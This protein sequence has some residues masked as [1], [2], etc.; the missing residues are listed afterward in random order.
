MSSQIIFG[1]YLSLALVWCY[2]AMDILLP[3]IPT[4]VWDVAHSF[5]VYWFCTQPMDALVLFVC[6]AI[7]GFIIMELALRRL[8]K[9]TKAFFH[10]AKAIAVDVCFLTKV[11]ALFVLQ[12]SKLY[13]V[14]AL[15]IFNQYSFAVVQFV[16]E[17]AT[18][19]R[20]RSAKGWFSAVLC[21]CRFAL[22]CL[23]AHWFM[24]MKAAEE[25]DFDVEN[26][27]LAFCI[28]TFPGLLCL[29]AHDVPSSV[30][31]WWNS[32]SDFCTPLSSRTYKFELQPQELNADEETDQGTDSDKATGT[33]QSEDAQ[34][35]DVFFDALTEINPSYTDAGTQTSTQPQLVISAVRTNVELF[36][37]IM[38]F[39]D[40]VDH[41]ALLELLRR[42]FDEK[43]ESDNS[44]QPETA[45]EPEKTEELDV[46]DQEKKP[47]R[48][49]HRW[50]N[51]FG[52]RKRMREAYTW[53]NPDP[54]QVAEPEIPPTD[55]STGED[56]KVSPPPAT[57]EP[58]EQRPDP[59]SL[60][61]E[62]Q[63]IMEAVA[64]AMVLQMS[65]RE[66]RHKVLQATLQAA[67]QTPLPAI[68]EKEVLAL[69]IPS[70]PAE[71]L[72]K[73]P[74]TEPFNGQGSHIQSPAAIKQPELLD[75]CVPSPPAEEPE[76]LPVTESLN[77]EGLDTQ[78]PPAAIKE[79]ELPLAGSP[80]DEEQLTMNNLSPVPA[81]TTIEEV[82]ASESSP[83]SVIFEPVL[84]ASNDAPFAPPNEEAQALPSGETAAQDVASSDA[85]I[86]EAVDFVL[87]EGFSIDD[88]EWVYPEEG[89]VSPSA[90]LPDDTVT[91]QP[92]DD[93]LD[94]G[95]IA[96]D[97]ASSSESPQQSTPVP[98]NNNVS[99]GA[100]IASIDAIPEPD[101]DENVDIGPDPWNT[102][103]RESRL[104]DKLYGHRL[105]NPSTS[106]NTETPPP[107]PEPTKA[108]ANP[109]EAKNTGTS[110]AANPFFTE[111]VE[112]PPSNPLSNKGRKRKS[113]KSYAAQDTEPPLKK[114]SPSPITETKVAKSSASR[115]KKPRSKKLFAAEPTETPLPPVLSPEITSSV[116]PYEVPLPPSPE[117]TSSVT[118]SSVALPPSPEITSSMDSFEVN[119]T[120]TS[121]ALE[122]L[123]A[124]T[125]NLS[126]SG[127]LQ[128]QRQKTKG[129]GKGRGSVSPLKPVAGKVIKRRA[130]VPFVI[131]PILLKPLITKSTGTSSPYSSGSQ[132][133]EDSAINNGSFLGAFGPAQS[134]ALVYTVP[135]TE[136]MEID[137]S[138]FKAPAT[139][140]HLSHS[141]RNGD[142]PMC[143][144][145][146]QPE[147]SGLRE[148]AVDAS[149]QGQ[150]DQFF[151]LVAIEE[152]DGDIE[153][154]PDNFDG[155]GEFEVPN[156]DL[157]DRIL[158]EDDE[159][160]G[161]E[162][163]PCEVTM[164]GANSQTHPGDVEMSPPAT[165]EPS[166]FADVDMS[167]PE[168]VEV[169]QHHG[170]E[171]SA[172]AAMEF[173]LSKLTLDTD[174]SRPAGFGVPQPET[175][176][177]EMSQPVEDRRT[178]DFVRTMPI[179]APVQ[180]DVAMEGS[181]TDGSMSVPTS[182]PMDDMTNMGA[183]LTN[184]G[185]SLANAAASPTGM[186]PP[187]AD[188]GNS[189][190][191]Q[192]KPLEASDEDDCFPSVINDAVNSEETGCVPS[193][194][195]QLPIQQQLPVQSR[196]A[197]Q[198][199]LQAD[200]QHQEE[201][202]QQQNLQQQEDDQQQLQHE[203][204]QP[205]VVGE[206]KC[207]QSQQEKDDA[208]LAIMTALVDEGLEEYWR[209][210]AE[211]E[212][213]AKEE[214]GKMKH[215]PLLDQWIT[216]AESSSAPL[217][218]RWTAGTSYG[219]DF[220]VGAKVDADDD[221]DEDSVE[222]S[223]EDSDDDDD[224]PI[225]PSTQPS[226]QPAAPSASTIPAT[227]S[228]PA[229]PPPFADPPMPA[230]S[231]PPRVEATS[232]PPVPVSSDQKE[233]SKITQ[234]G[235]IAQS[236]NP[237]AE[238]PKPVFQFGSSRPTYQEYG[239][240]HKEVL[241]TETEI[242]A[243]P[244]ARAVSRRTTG[245]I[246]QAPQPTSEPPTAT[247][248]SRSRRT[249]RPFL[250]T[251][252]IR[253]NEMGEP[254]TESE[255]RARRKLRPVGV[256]KRTSTASL[257][258]TQET[259]AAGRGSLPPGV[260]QK[261]DGK[262]EAGEPDESEWDSDMDSL[263]GIDR[264]EANEDESPVRAPEP[265]SAAQRPEEAHQRANSRGQRQPQRPLELVLPPGAVEA[266]RQ[267]ELQRR[268]QEASHQQDSAMDDMDMSTSTPVSSAPA[269]PSRRQSVMAGT[270][271]SRGSSSR[272]GSMHRGL[273][274]E[275]PRPTRTTQGSSVAGEEVAGRQTTPCRGS[276]QSN[277][278]DLETA[279]RL[280]AS[281]KAERQSVGLFGADDE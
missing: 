164:P 102:P 58:S 38:G 52:R 215:M 268:A 281:Q 27:G 103:V 241:N 36:P 93:D 177:V 192:A 138:T 64:M 222:D 210:E 163:E 197:G 1:Y 136:R 195:R 226:T 69:H 214:E 169:H 105:R 270:P 16:K 128:S 252:D 133:R 39:S 218:D 174:M 131:A 223:V 74:I 46:S 54:P 219:V 254:S 224:I 95:K 259:T 62:G 183:P 112:P 247:T 275:S 126:T 90:F 127:P 118:P 48:R 76:Q 280:M 75:P 269:I 43:A 237:A 196:M 97:I 109:F 120:A 140:S 157:L 173:G 100:P 117:V 156:S 21:L 189:S 84:E 248:A 199:Q 253:H 35:E 141:D 161:G 202:Q 176:D 243:R 87:E 7:T 23:W 143:D 211:K 14:M 79:S 277:L 168:D 42:R 122:S 171:M 165:Y 29:L 72:E 148:P 278:L 113:K 114:S 155:Q 124:N 17:H 185:D 225:R 115:V 158:R 227:P 125:T 45:K 65:E 266:S 26:F 99:S 206:L 67:I 121:S 129:K 153:M 231:T 83:V 135:V 108:A 4:P 71:E 96:S 240:H 47:T 55:P 34:D 200:Q 250:S 37:P 137:N 68:K 13:A 98:E 145:A 239:D 152:D 92:P 22:V 101:S 147:Q 246:V 134:A 188:M 116:N 242:A 244:K 162:L 104:F 89:Y 24:Q 178:D 51:P 186:T 85:P 106:Q 194:H 88:H 107:K 33:N 40:E 61:G 216:K 144:P 111:T 217:V 236:A 262:E 221:S 10:V 230:S 204:Q 3:L 78:S 70:P 276:Q 274:R 130:P 91:E 31:V 20:Q 263:F 149:L 81:Q 193:S 175:N 213:K 15:E 60:T 255:I 2:N 86:D 139:P 256:G 166:R 207:L 203:D 264:D 257:T 191:G 44:P 151:A 261:M 119:G 260:G 267:A 57:D 28:S 80:D 209:E 11:L 41:I 212:A 228:A 159:A 182:G 146:L 220:N 132:T 154:T 180:Q 172:T 258:T 5:Y 160:D 94:L 273:F 205:A 238:K 25:V 167:E 59:E 12:L 82:E 179:H 235:S 56:S 201:L 272:R 53:Y 198:E 208:E 271:N 110:S 181:H 190:F 187:E 251:N 19:I 49:K 18:A 184:M 63:S 170:A 123:F 142:S 234:A 6:L 9:F 279:A 249:R 73:L 32:F 30:F 8:V 50:S 232:P 77:G 229:N 245:Q 150:P 66:W 265:K 233:T